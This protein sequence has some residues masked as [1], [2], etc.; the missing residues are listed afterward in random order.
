MNNWLLGFKLK[1][2]RQKNGLSLQEVAEK[3]GI[4]A[5]FLSLVEN[6]HSGI[7]IGNL[8]STLTV[9]G[10]KL[11]DLYETE[12]ED[13]RVLHLEQCEHLGFDVDGLE[14][15]ILINDPQ[16]APIFPVH[17]RLKPGAAIGPISHTGNEICFIIEGTLEF[18]IQNPK[19]GE[20][21][22]HVAEKWDTI[23]YSGSGLHT[24][25][26]I[27]NTTAILYSVIYYTDEKNPRRCKAPK[28][29]GISVTRNDKY[30]HKKI[31]T[32]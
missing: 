18:L 26:N 16:N 23:T 21:D 19:T 15:Y 30:K 14:S 11:A 12:G 27:S 5:A 3:V 9:Y 10:N 2:M 29:G 8:Q 22:R 24:V 25:T 32:A 6:G 17:F 1:Q 20:M 31:P 7:S 13:D 4:T 28:N